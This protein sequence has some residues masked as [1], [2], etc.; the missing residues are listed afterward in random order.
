M[1]KRVMRFSLPFI[2]PAEDRE[3]P[4]TRAMEEAAVL[5]LAEMERDKGGGFI[6]K[7]EAEELV[8][9]AG[10]RYPIWLVPLGGRSLL[11]DGFSIEAHVLSHDVLPDV[12]AFIDDL[13]GSAETREAY[14]AFLHD[15]LNF[16]RNFK[17]Q[18]E[19][20]I[21][22]FITSSDLVQG[23]ISY[24]PE[25]RRTGKAVVDEIILSP[26]LDESAISSS[27]HE[28]SSHRAALK[29]DVNSLRQAMKLLNAATDKHTRIIRDEIKKTREEFDKEFAAVR[30]SAMEK[31]RTIQKKYDQ[32]IAK[33]SKQFDQQLQ[34]LHRERIKAEKAGERLSVGVDR[35][36]VEIASCRLYNDEAGEL[37]WRQKLEEYK[38]E[39]PTVEK[40]IKDLHKRIDEVETAKRREVSEI[41]AEYDAQAE[42]AM[43]NLRELEASHEAEK[44]MR[45]Q[46]IQKLEELS[47]EIVNQIDGLL[48]RRREAL[49]EFGGMGIP[50]RR[51]KYALV[52]LPFYLACY[53]RGLKKRY[54]VYPPSRAMGMGAL[55]RFKGVFGAAKIKS[56]LENRSKPITNLLNQLIPLIVR[57]PVFEKEIGDAGSRADIL[58]TKESRER[59]QKGLEE[60]KD[61]G[62]ISEGEL[63]EFDS[64]LKT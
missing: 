9:V 39:L 25:A 43:G 47:S 36:E 46:E 28:L 45:E 52:H 7:R 62:W 4:F 31:R 34:V 56:I 11:V 16:F 44:R 32:E 33:R 30:S 21:E 19:R 27:L 26:T 50:K 8:F 35:C 60:L 49:R 2:V 23:L 51:R 18:E 13:Q 40:S 54:V 22:G 15:H 41:R 37:Q 55:T 17:G 10:A 14:L 20:R 61:E 24:F 64:L 6:S 38:K 59:V 42:A 63:S 48:E 29:M 1:S 5:C 12:Q 3:K 53:R 58:R 57:N